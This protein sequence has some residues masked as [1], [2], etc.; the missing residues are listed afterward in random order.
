MMGPVH[1]NDTNTSV[2]AMKKMLRKPVVDSALLSIALDQRDG[3]FISNAPK[4]DTA[5]TTRSAKNSTLNSA[6]VAISLSL[7]APNAMVM[8]MPSTRYITM[9]LTA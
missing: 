4:N 2:N 5:K 9:M 8:A 1:E 3:S 7:L 6:E